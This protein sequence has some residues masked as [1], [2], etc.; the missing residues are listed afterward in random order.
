MLSKDQI[1]SVNVSVQIIR[2]SPISILLAGSFEIIL[3]IMDTV[4]MND[5][6]TKTKKVKW[7]LNSEGY[8]NCIWTDLGTEKLEI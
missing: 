3:G 2:F 6:I 1:D 5:V 4:F 8:L 7:R